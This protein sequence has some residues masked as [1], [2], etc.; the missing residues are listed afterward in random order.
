MWEISQY[1]I[2]SK[3][4]LSSKTLFLLVTYYELLVFK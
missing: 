3:H 1:S 2:V 4:S